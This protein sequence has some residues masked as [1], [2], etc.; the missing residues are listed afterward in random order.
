[1]SDCQH[2]SLIWMIAASIIVNAC[3]HFTIMLALYR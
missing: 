1:M 2:K 3:F